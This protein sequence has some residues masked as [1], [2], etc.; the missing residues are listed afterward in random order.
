MECSQWQISGKKMRLPLRRAFA[1]AEMDY[2]SGIF[3]HGYMTDDAETKR[4]F[5]M[6]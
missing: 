2:F 1:L 3:Y 4:A 5:P 6:V